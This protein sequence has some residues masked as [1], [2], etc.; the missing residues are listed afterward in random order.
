MPSERYRRSTTTFP[1]G[2]RIP[3][4]EPYPRTAA[5]CLQDGRKYNPH[6]L[7]ALKAFRRE[8]PWRGT[9][10]ERKEKF[11]RVHRAL[12]AAYGL[13]TRLRFHVSLAMDNASG[14]SCYDPR[15]NMIELRG[16]LSVVTYLHEFGHAL[17]YGEQGTCRWSINLFRRVFPRSY[18]R[19]QPRGH[20]LGRGPLL[21]SL[22]ESGALQQDE[23][24]TLRVA[25]H[26]ERER[27]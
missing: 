10:A 3:P 15:A 20:V 23:R 13:T 7:R 6:V 22:L 17:G 1:G 9:L 25:S 18:S 4:N 21:S 27:N 8:K 24:G 19:L 5:E 16:R 26:N 11:R 2:G 14:A 12:C